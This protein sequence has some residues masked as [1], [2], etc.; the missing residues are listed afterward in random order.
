MRFALRYALFFAPVLLL[1]S[2]ATLAALKLVDRI[3]RFDVFW[4]AA[5]RCAPPFVVGLLGY[6]VIAR[7]ARSVYDKA[8]LGQHIVRALPLYLIAC[9][10]LAALFL[11]LSSPDGDSTFQ[12]LVGPGF[13]ALGGILGDLT[14][15]SLA[16]T[17]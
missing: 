9:L 4:T 17:A 1:A 3:A 10:A 15:T 2:A 16:D 11:K 5:A 12:F 7:R 13:A 14:A 8:T 6:Y